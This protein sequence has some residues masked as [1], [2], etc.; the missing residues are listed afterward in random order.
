[1][2]LAAPSAISIAAQLAAGTHDATTLLADT[3]A[4]N[5]AQDA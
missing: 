2:T 1:M 5:D 4:R 3:Q